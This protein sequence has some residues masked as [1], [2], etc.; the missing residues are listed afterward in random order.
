MEIVSIILRLKHQEIKV[1]VDEAKELLGQLTAVFGGEKPI[2]Q[3]EYVPYGIPYPVPQPYPVYPQPKP[4]WDPWYTKPYWENQPI[5]IFDTGDTG[6][7]S[8]RDNTCTITS[9]TTG[10]LIDSITYGIGGVG[11]SSSAWQDKSG[12]SILGDAGGSAGIG[13]QVGTGVVFHDVKSDWNLGRSS[14]LSSGSVSIQ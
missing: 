3:K 12:V 13:I 11:Q 9:G 2:I 1:T 10:D 8:W 6:K 7:I 14:G 5:L 4:W